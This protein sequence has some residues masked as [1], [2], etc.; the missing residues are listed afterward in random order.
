MVNE[1]KAARP[2]TVDDP[3]PVVSVPAQRAPVH[4]EPNERMSRLALV[5]VALVVVAAAS[6]LFMSWLVL[7]SPLIDAIGET[8][9]S[10][11]LGLVL[12]SILG[13]LRRSRR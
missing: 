6:W 2:S 11:A 4:D 8:G 9:G 1:R 7:D 12:V 5:M 10:V 3:A 13:A